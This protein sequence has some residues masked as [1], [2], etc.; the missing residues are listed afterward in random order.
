ML[1][2]GNYRCVT[3]TGPREINRTVHDNLDE[4]RSVYDFVAGLCV[5]L[6][7]DPSDMVPFEK[8]AAAAQGLSRPSSAARALFAGAQNIERAD[9]LVQLIGRQKGKSHPVLDATV[10]L[11]DAQLQ[12]N[13]AAAA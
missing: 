12:R 2:A 8:Y 6:G 5:S 11:V 7:A 9:K 3:P 4:S 13:R 10:A 1:L